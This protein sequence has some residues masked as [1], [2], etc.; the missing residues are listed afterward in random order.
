MEEAQSF[1]QEK[2][3]PKIDKQIKNLLK[4]AA[5]WAEIKDY[6]AD[7]VLEEKEYSV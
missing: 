1:L 6:T 7:Y 3:Q 5:E 4:R 2:P